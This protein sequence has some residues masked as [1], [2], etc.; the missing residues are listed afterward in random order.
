MSK[1]LAV[2][3]RKCIHKEFIAKLISF[4]WMFSNYIYLRNTHDNYDVTT[5]IFFKTLL[6]P[7]AYTTCQFLVINYIK[8]IDKSL[9]PKYQTIST[10]FGS[11]S[12]V[13]FLASCYAVWAL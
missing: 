7:T 13:L 12:A 4:V 1:K 8:Y 10:L 11:F 9:L 5:L 6:L 3:A 2:W